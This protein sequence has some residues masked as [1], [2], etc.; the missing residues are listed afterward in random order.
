M[1]SDP[2]CTSDSG[3]S[4]GSDRPGVPVVAIVGG[5]AAGTLTAI[6]LLRELR[7]R[8]AP[9]RG[10]DIL[11]VDPAAETGRGVAYSTTDDR[12]LLNVPAGGLSA[13]PDEPD[14]FLRWAQREVDESSTAGDF[15]PRKVYGAY[16]SAVLAETAA[17]STS[18]VLTRVTVRVVGLEAGPGDRD[19]LH[20]SDGTRLSADAVV[21]APGVF[22]PSTAWAPASLLTSDRFVPDPWAPGA[23]GDVAESDGDVLLVGTGLTMVDVVLSLQRPGRT[24]HAVSRRGRLPQ[25]HAATAQAPVEPTNLPDDVHIDIATLREAVHAHI[26][27]TVREH[28][29][30]RPAMDG[31]RAHS[32]RLWSMLCEPC[33]AEFLASDAS[34]WDLHR[35]RM[36]RSTAR[37]VGRLRAD[38][39]LQV[40]TGEVAAVEDDGSA[41]LV[42]LSDGSTR[43][44][45]HV[46]NCTGPLSDVSLTGDPLLTRLLADGRVVP[47]PLR[48]GLSTDRDGRVRAA[49]GTVGPMWT[50]GSMRRGELWES[51]AVPEIRVQAAAIAAAVVDSVVVTRRA[52]ARRAPRDLMGLPLSTSSSAARAYN[53]GLGRVLRVQAGADD[54]FREAV[55]LD[56][57]FSS[58]HAALALLGH[59]GGASADVAASLAAAQR[60]ASRK[61][62][63]RERSL[64]EVVTARVADCRGVG[65]A[66]L[67]GHIAA[68]PR[69]A[70]AVSAAVP[71]IA[72]SGVT[73]VQQEAWELVESLA[74]AYGQD[75]WYAGLLA[76]VR[77]DQGRYDEA[78]ALASAALRVEPASGHAVHAQTHVYYETGQ[79][80]AGLRWLDPWITTSGR[81]ASHGAHF[82]WHAAL[83]EL[84]LGDIDSLRHRYATQLAPPNVTGV[85]A[86]VDSA[87]LLWRCRMTGVWTDDLPL[88]AVLDLV[89]DELLENPTTPFTAMHSALAL[90]AAGDVDGLLRLRGHVASSPEPVMRDVVV[91]LCDALVAL[92]RQDWGE[93]VRILRLL[94]PW[95]VQLGGSAAQREIVEDTL[96]YALVQA[97]R[98]DEARLLL[99]ARLDRRPSPMDLRRLAGVP[100]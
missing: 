85:R 90:T 52:A 44:V 95:L 48:M 70:L 65:A 72:F 82:S 22:A 3:D 6:H 28:G 10:V 14:Q 88:Q 32:G 99:E 8:R 21:L 7:G 62:T 35:H 71:T 49:D 26:S 81:S 100:A 91:S 36:P 55:A 76:F 12:H 20:L 29:D 56:P 5:G 45:A 13:L 74:P 63:D 92:V 1:S 16:L 67:V 79:H 73:D 15:L 80:A 68:H 33:R 34:A 83:H 2:A 24:I 39:A 37:T 53:T 58:A 30:W 31:L 27:E 98:C 54:A 18:A 50:L 11:L 43:R 57:D 69:D 59:E 75:W 38:G 9:A 17:A 19:V 84:S 87:S 77:Q 51:T 47:G 60:A 42:S 25:V 89:G 93:A 94:G 96:L 4:A 23:L 78:D 40:A 61:G 97:E 66:A 41:L 46:V 86:L 64:V